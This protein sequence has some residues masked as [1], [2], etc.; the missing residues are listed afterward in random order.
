M[1]DGEMRNKIR[2]GEETSE[3]GQGEGVALRPPLQ[4]ATGLVVDHELLLRST[5]PAILITAIKLK[6][7]R[8]NP[9]RQTDAAVP[10]WQRIL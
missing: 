4:A 2:T 6:S 3:G 7:H 8:I 1:S 9:C 10:L 5:R